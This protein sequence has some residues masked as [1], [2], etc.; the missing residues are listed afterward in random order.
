MAP[1]GSTMKGLNMAAI[2]IYRNSYS[3]EVKDLAEKYKNKKVSLSRIGKNH[4]D[5]DTK[6][7]LLKE[8]EF[9]GNVPLRRKILHVL[10]N[11]TE[12]PGCE[13]CDGPSSWDKAGDSGYN[14][15]CSQ[16]CRNLGSNRK[17]TFSKEFLIDEHH[18]KQKTMEQ[19]AKENDCAC[20]TN[21]VKRWL[22]YYDIPIIDYKKKNQ[23]VLQYLEDY[24]WLYNKYWNENKTCQQIANDLGYKTSKTIVARYLHIN[25]IEVKN[26]NYYDR[27][28]PKQSSQEREII[29]FI[30]SLNPEIS[31]Y[32]NNRQFFD[33]IEMDIFL[34]EYG[35]AIEHHGLL[36]HSPEG[37]NGTDKYLHKQ[38]ADKCQ[39]KGVQLFQIIQPEWTFDINKKEIWK[40]MISNKLGMNEKIYARNCEIKE[41]DTTT[42]NHFLRLNHIQG[43]D[44]S[45]VKIGIFYNSELY[46][47]MTFIKSRFNKSYEWELSRFSVKCF[48][49]IIGGF[50]KALSYFEENY[51]PKSIVTYADRRYSEGNVYRKHDFEELTVSKPNYHYFYNEDVLLNRKNFRKSFLKDKLQHFDP[52]KTEFQNMIDAGY[53]TFWDAGL[54]TFGKKY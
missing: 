24:D 42:K 8:T 10:W 43:Q 30:H 27:E 35:L 9:L 1:R 5:Y 16:N 37:L 48:T 40:S 21:P 32:K 36:F 31:I 49:N 2:N 17:F 3:K 15:F 51:K 26:S 28:F 44:S 47:V 46:G 6:Q 7:Q 22:K 33:G 39:E 34:P 11:I 53:K 41:I 52:E 18:N 38:K 23:K 12:I 29:D 19:I 54:I 4:S 25:E 20:S 13:Y 50:S 14:R 45:S